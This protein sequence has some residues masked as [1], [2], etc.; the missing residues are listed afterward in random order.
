MLEIC[1]NMQI[2][3]K[4]MQKYAKKNAEICIKYVKYAQKICTNMQ[5]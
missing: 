4:Y 2:Y 1:N 3:A 5:K